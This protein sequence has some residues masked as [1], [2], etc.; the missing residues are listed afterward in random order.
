VI[1][2]EFLRIAETLRVPVM[3]TEN[4]ALLLYSLTR[5]LRP[6]TVL[7]IGSGYTTMFLALG[8]ADAAAEA[9]VDRD[10][11]LHEPKGDRGR[12]LTDHATRAY[13]PTLLALD[14]LKDPR[15]SAGRLGDALAL[16]GLADRVTLLSRSFKAA[17]TSLGLAPGSLDL[18]WFDC[19]AS[20]TKGI[21]FLNEYW[22]L[23]SDGGV[24][25]LHSMRRPLPRSGRRSS[26][27]VAA[28]L[29]NEILRRHAVAGTRRRF[30]ILSLAE[31]HKAVQ[32]DV[33]LLKKVGALDAIRETEFAAAPRH[34]DDTPPALAVLK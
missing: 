6:R 28:G 22:P 29:L 32:G 11:L 30:E 12:L 23:V 13:S 9:A 2:A 1:T 19:G 26:T 15:T 25:G 31:P 8:L 18:I 20:S 14:T 21:E 16:A 34:G 33:V 17:S 7:E 4:V 27:T 5:M 10:V 24:V 3:G